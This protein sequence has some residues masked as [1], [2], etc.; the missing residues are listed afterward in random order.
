[1]I[2]GGL[3]TSNTHY[4]ARRKNIYTN[5][6]KHDN[7][8]TSI[9]NPPK[10]SCLWG[11]DHQIENCC[12]MCTGAEDLADY[13]PNLLSDPQW[14]CGRHKRV[15]IFASYLVSI[16]V[17]SGMLSCADSTF[18]EEITVADFKDHGPGQI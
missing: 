14:P 8:C 11:P 12:S 5:D 17:C 15:L 18:C 16:C 13:D 9:R 6:Y 4:F 1:M 2:G 3:E 10:S 7:I